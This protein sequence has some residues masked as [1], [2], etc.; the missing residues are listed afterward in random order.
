MIRNTT[1]DSPGNVSSYEDLWRFTLVNYSS[2]P[3][4]LS[5]A[6]LTANSRRV[7]MDWENV[8]P[9]LDESCSIAVDYVEDI[10][11]LPSFPPSPT[12]GPPSLP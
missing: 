8:S 11:L 12:P 6:L 1:G 3:G 7:A 9:L 5:D 4:C 2:G 10:S